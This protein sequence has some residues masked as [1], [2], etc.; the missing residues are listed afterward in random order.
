MREPFFEMLKMSMAT[1][2]NAMTVP[3]CTYYPV[4]SNTR[5]DLFNLAEVYFDAVFHPLL[6]EVSFKREGHHLAP[7]DPDD[8]SGALSVTGIVYNEMKGAYSSPLARLHRGAMRKLLPDTIYG[9]SSGG[10]PEA[11]PDLTYDSFRRYHAD[12]YQP[13][14]A[15]FFLYGDIPTRD[16]L[17]FLSDRLAG[18]TSRPPVI[19]LELQPRWSAARHLDDTYPI[20]PGEATD[21][22]SYLLLAWLAADATDVDAS[23]EWYLLDTILLGHEA[24]PL[25][26]A[27]IDS[28]IGAD[29]VSSGAFP[30]GREIVFALG[31]KDSEAD[32]IDRFTELVVSTLSDIA[33]RGVTAEEVN[34]ALQQATYHYQEIQPMY[35]LHTPGSGPRR[36]DLRHGSADVPEAGRTPGG[37][38]PAVPRRSEAVRAADPGAGAV[39]CAP[40][41]HLSA[42]RS[43][44]A[45]T[46]RCGVHG[47][48]AR[49][50]REPD[51]RRYPTD[52]RGGG[53]AAAQQQ[54]AQQ[55]GGA[56]QAA[57]AYGRRPAGGDHARRHRRA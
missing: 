35:P 39:Q 27:I 26:K 22:K 4:A 20:D 7:A 12:H 38:P 11:I 30:L 46:H 52:L 36:L 42:S 45:G 9:R 44:D 14:N 17:D 43:G 53:R 18:L 25:R 5:K 15:Y 6:S 23:I 2:I 21:G 34:T 31:V 55:P 16:Y 48:D 32:H 51:R 49:A 41:E 10:E 47:A 37:V 50:A 57:A 33:D 19:D 8:P 24:A 13:G 3:D 28:G 1:F 54:P 56:R 29:M 40:L